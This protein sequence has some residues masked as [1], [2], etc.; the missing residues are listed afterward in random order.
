MIPG[1]ES[2]SSM[3][4]W[5][6]PRPSAFVKP[7]EGL[8]GRKETTPSV[9]FHRHHK[10]PVLAMAIPGYGVAEQVLVGGFGTF[11]SI[12]NTVITGRI[13]LSWFPQAQS[14]GILQPV[15]AITD[16]Y[17]NLFR[18][19]IPPIFGLDLSPILAFV[20]LNLLTSATASVGCDL[21]PNFSE[22]NN[23]FSKMVKKGKNNMGV[24]SS[25]I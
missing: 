17:L 20:T 11:L 24:Q 21:P 19:I 23:K 18:G 2:T 5:K 4:D 1:L 16:P 9:S 13:L 7:G 6:T 25:A 3:A 14:I 10:Q 12:F 15:F 8:Y 22:K